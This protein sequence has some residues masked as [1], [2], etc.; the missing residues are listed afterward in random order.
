MVKGQVRLEITLHGRP[1]KMVTHI[2]C[3]DT[4]SENSYSGI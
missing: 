2:Y 3:L 4:P 1:K